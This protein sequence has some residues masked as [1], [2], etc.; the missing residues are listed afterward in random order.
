MNRIIRALF[1]CNIYVI[2]TKETIPAD[3]LKLLADG[4]AHIKRKATTRQRRLPIKTE[5]PGE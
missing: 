5:G 2:T 4:Q 1:G 3:R